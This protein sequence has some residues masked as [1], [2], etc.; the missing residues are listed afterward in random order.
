MNRR[1]LL[2][3]L[4]RGDLQNIAFDDMVSLVEGFGFGLERTHGSHHLFRH[5]RIA[6][7]VNLQ[8]HRGD[9]KPYQVRQFLR[10]VE[11]FNLELED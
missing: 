7:K 6:V 9:A 1:K 4:S 11:Q 10:I 3:R 8:E 5:P 2:Q